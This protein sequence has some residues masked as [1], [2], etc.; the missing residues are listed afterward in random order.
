[1]RRI[2]TDEPSADSPKTGGDRELDTA[3]SATFVLQLL[4][5]RDGKT[6]SVA[7]EM[8]VNRCTDLQHRCP[9]AAFLV[10]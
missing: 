10:L 4:A 1:M 6:L 8:I 3:R 2:T 7:F 5:R 9:S